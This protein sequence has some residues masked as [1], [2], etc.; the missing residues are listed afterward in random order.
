MKKLMIV[1]A[2][3][4]IFASCG[5]SQTQ[6]RSEERQSLIAKGYKETLISKSSVIDT[7]G[8]TLV[9]G[10]IAVIEGDTIVVKSVQ[11]TDYYTDHVTVLFPK[12]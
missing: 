6:L 5:P 10:F 9:S 7:R 4:L 3:T 2:A 1:V 8:R 12:S 11:I